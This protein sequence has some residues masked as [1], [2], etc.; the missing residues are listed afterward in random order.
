MVLIMNTFKYENTVLSKTLSVVLALITVFILS[1]LFDYS[2]WYYFIIIICCGIILAC[3]FELLQHKNV[4][5][6]TGEYRV[7][8]TSLYIK[9]SSGETE[10]PMDMVDDIIANRTNLFSTAYALKIRTGKSFYSI[11]S[12]TVPKHCDFFDTSLSP[13]VSEI[14]KAN[15][16]LEYFPPQSENNVYIWKYTEK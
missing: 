15:S 2:N 1:Y 6:K 16:Q 9:K 4:F 10:I 11:H 5:T 12:E 14:V 13:L 3:L 8:G 7:E